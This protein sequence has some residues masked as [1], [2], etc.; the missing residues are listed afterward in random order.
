MRFQNHIFIN[1]P[2]PLGSLKKQFYVCF[3]LIDFWLSGVI[4]NAES[5]LVTYSWCVHSLTIYQIVPLGASNRIP[6]NISIIDSSVSCMPSAEFLE[7][8]I[9]YL[10]E[11]ETVFENIL[12]SVWWAKIEFIDN[13]GGSKISRHTSFK[14]LSK[15]PFVVTNAYFLICHNRKWFHK[16]IVGNPLW[17]YFWNL[18]G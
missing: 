12:T 15:V 6:T 14:I 10:G 8:K 7:Q 18:W 2:P 5:N 4:D 11:I 9:Q 3:D 13:K 17:P 1:P 16:W